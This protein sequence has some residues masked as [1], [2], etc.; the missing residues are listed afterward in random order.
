MKYLTGAAI[1]LLLLVAVVVG[2][3]AIVANWHAI[4]GVLTFL[5]LGMWSNV[6]APNFWSLAAVGMSYVSLRIRHKAKEKR[7]QQRH[8]E[9]KREIRAR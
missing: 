1:D 7:D 6:F 9:L 3:V 5:W 2:I 4:A 8:E